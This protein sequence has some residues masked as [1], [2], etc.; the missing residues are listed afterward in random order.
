MEKYRVLIVDD[1]E[2]IR[3]LYTEELK[4]RGYEVDTADSAEIVEAKIREFKPDIITLDIKLPGLDG[5]E[6]LRKL[7]ED[8]VQIPVILCS[9]YPHFKQDFRS[10]A[11]EAYV[12]KSSQVDELVQTI[13]EILKNRSS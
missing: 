11:S 6:L 1:E 7:R 13:Q 5:I 3:L 2:N 9:A 10:W 8:H 4:D 12:V